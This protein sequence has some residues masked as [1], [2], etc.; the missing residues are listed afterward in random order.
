MSQ[1]VVAL[2]GVAL[3]AVCAL[4]REY[5]LERR[6]EA[7]NARAAA[8]LL[9]DAFLDVSFRL[10]WGSESARPEIYDFNDAVEEW[11]EHRTALARSLTNEEWEDVVSAAQL[12]TSV[13]GS[14][15]GEVGRPVGHPEDEETLENGVT[16][17]ALER[18]VL[19][20]LSNR[21]VRAAT[22]L[23]RVAAGR[24]AARKLKREAEELNAEVPVG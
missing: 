4:A 2:I 16:V 24:S 7:L 23:E 14:R 12:L 11:R 21:L 18:A 17:E 20:M 15:R 5:T 22:S 10:P 6:T 1:T 9:R 13:T 3:G 19:E 8:R